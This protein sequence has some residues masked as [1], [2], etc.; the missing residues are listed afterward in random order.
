MQIKEG[1]PA[2]ASSEIEVA[3]PPEVVWDVIADFERWPD[4]E[5]VLP[6]LLRGRMQKMLQESLD[7]ALPRLKAEAER[8][9]AA[10]APPS[11]G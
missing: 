8:R 5:G 2:V 9:S 6:R 3:A 10:Q 7:N 1:A 4:W 11:S